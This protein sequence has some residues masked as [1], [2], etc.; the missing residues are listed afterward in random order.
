LT[1]CRKEE[2][3]SDLVDRSISNYLAACEKEEDLCVMNE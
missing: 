3:F 2:W 1:I